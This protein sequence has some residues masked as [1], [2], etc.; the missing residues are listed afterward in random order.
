MKRVSR[1]HGRLGA[2]LCTVLLAGCQSNKM[3]SAWE[4]IQQQQQE[5]ALMRQSEDDPD[6]G[7]QPTEPQLMLALIRE[8]QAQG[9]Y[10]ASLAYIDAYRQRF[11]NS[12]QLEALQADA[13]R[14]TG[15]QEQSEA[16]YRKLLGGAQAAQG[17][18]GLGLLAG[19]RGDYAQAAQDLEHA[20]KLAPTDA[21][22]L[23]DLG[24]A[25]LRA[26][27]SAGAR[28]PL[29]KA[30]E[31]DPSNTK[32]LANMALLLVVEGN[33]VQAQQLMDRARLGQD[34]RSQIYQLASQMQAQGR[35]GSTPRAQGVVRD[36]TRVSG[37]HGAT[38]VSSGRDVVMPMLQP[39]M[40]RMI[41]PPMVQ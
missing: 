32:V 25:R 7:K 35:A 28:V 16:A 8:N 40:D 26:G 30:A 33:A 34:A 9:R 39:V 27:D 3:E 10:F 29:G 14:R 18:H 37:A 13:L 19:A 36:V 15:Q 38:Q 1:P 4:L 17:W 6:A 11:G 41:N 22:M 20:V 24:Y 5:Q 31:L 23:G 2:V 21:Q 12:D